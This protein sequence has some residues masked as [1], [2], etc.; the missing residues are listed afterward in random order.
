MKKIKL[1]KGQFTLVD[2]EDFEKLNK[3]K[4]HVMSVGYAG[5]TIGSEK[6]KNRKMVL[7]HRVI[8][9]T[10]KGFV[11][12]HINRNK[13]DNRKKNLRTVSHAQNLWNMGLTKQN[14]LGCKGV[15]LFVNGKYVVSISIK[16]KQKHLGYFFTIE[17]AKK[18]YNDAVLKY[19]DEF[20]YMN[21]L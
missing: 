20:S 19:R 9:E 5:R 13:L 16:N 10:P 6:R 11:T 15:R 21:N 18:A 2:D 12:D 1:D 14:K 3:Y 8:M 17:E 7:M 4:W